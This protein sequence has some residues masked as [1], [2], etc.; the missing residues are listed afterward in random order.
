MPDNNDFGSFGKPVRKRRAGRFFSY[1]AVFLL[2]VF[3][4]PA[5]FGWTEVYQNFVE[6]ERPT[7]SVN[8]RPYGIG[9][10][11][12]KLEVV[13]NDAG[14]GLDEVIV[15]A[16]QDG[17]SW[18]LFKRQ[19]PTKVNDD[20]ISVQLPNKSTGLKEGE[21]K[22][23]VIAFDRTF[24]ANRR[25]FPMVFPVSF[26][27]PKVEPVSQQHNAVVGGASMVFFHA[28]G[29]IAL[30]S[31]RSGAEF[32]PG[33]LAKN[34]DKDF[35]AAPDLYFVLFPVPLGFKKS[36]QKIYLDAVDKVGNHSQVS[37]PYTIREELTRDKTINISSDYYDQKIVP[38]FEKYVELDAKWRSAPREQFLPATTLD[39]KIRRFRDVNEKY[40]ELIE[41]SLKPLFAHPKQIRYWNGKFLRLPGAATVGNF[42]EE[43][44]YVME[45]QSAGSSI[46]TGV[47]LSSTPRAA[48]RA[49]NDGVV[50]FADELGIYG[51]A[52]IVDHGF[53]LTSLYGHLSKIKVSE[54]DQVHKGD[55]IGNTGDTGLAEGDHLHFEIRLHG[56]PV[57]PIEWWDEHWISDHI[58]GQ[59]LD[60]KKSLGIRIT[61]IL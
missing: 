36:E 59:M 42:G 45:G 29:D 47:D 25:H 26:H 4:V 54:G 13:L 22:V 34:L 35:E 31:V 3:A 20:V 2:A 53:G 5:Y 41:R 16:E 23:T 43:R 28:T 37:F 24:W 9:L 30:T 46:H 40:R 38:L 56:I 51:N 18:E 14:S 8:N 6:K 21:L 61:K 1:L 52:V 15:R 60:T 48:A 33:F 19:Y 58:E 49:A 32:V 44:N 39:E 57:R 7:I 17:E 50:I 27:P 55:E 10:E 11:S 12:R